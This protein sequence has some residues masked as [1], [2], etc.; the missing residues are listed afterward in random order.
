[1]SKKLDKW[2]D[3]VTV[4][5]NDLSKVDREVL[6]KVVDKIEAHNKKILQNVRTREKQ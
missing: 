4:W 2:W 3:D 1:M 6:V 5:L